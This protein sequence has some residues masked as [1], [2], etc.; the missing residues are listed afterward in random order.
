MDVWSVGVVMF[1]LLTGEMPFDDEDD[2][3]DAMQYDELFRC[4]L[5]VLDLFN[6]HRP[7]LR[8]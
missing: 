6:K 3:V 8:S 4:V 1:F 5:P 7:L 2:R